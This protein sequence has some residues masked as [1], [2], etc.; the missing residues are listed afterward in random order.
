MTPKEM[1]ICLEQGL[2]KQASFVYEDY[3][4]EEY[5]GVLTKVMVRFINDTFRPDEQG[6]GFAVDMNIVD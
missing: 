1:H 6:E 3:L 2:Q 4:K 5:D